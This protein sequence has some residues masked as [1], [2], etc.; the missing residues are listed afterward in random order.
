MS[1]RLCL[2]LWLLMYVHPAHATLPPVRV[3]KA[4]GPTY[5]NTFTALYESLAAG[6]PATAQAQA[7]KVNGDWRLDRPLDI[8]CNGGFDSGFT[9]GTGYTTLGGTL[10]VGSG[11][12]TANRLIVS[13]PGTAPL[14]ALSGSGSVARSLLTYADL[15]G[16]VTPALVDGSAF[17]LPANAAMPAH[18]FEGHL[19]IPEAGQSPV[20]IVHTDDYS[21]A[22]T[23][24]RKVLPAFSFDFVQN[25][26]YLIPATQGLSITGNSYWNYIVG[27]GRVW[28]ETGDQGLSRAS[29]P[30]ALVERNANCTHNGMMT[31]LFDNSSVSK[32]SYE[33][34]QETCKYFKLD[35]AGQLSASY[36]PASVAGAAAIKA[37]HAAE[38]ANRLPT[39]PIAALVDDFP[40]SGVQL[41]NIGKMDQAEHM[42][43]YGLLVNGINY[44]SDCGT[45]YG[46]YPFCD[47]MRLPSYSTAKSAFASMAMMRLG[48]KYGK[49]L[50]Y[51]S[52]IVD[53]IYPPEYQSRPGNWNYQDVTT[54][55]NTLDMAT[56]RF[57]YSEFETDENYYMT[58]FFLAENYDST[59]YY[60]FQFTQYL[61]PGQRWV[62]HSS[63]TFLVTRAMNNFLVYYANDTGKDI[64]NMV[65][66]EVFKPLHLSAG[67]MTTLRT[68]NSS[69]GKP[70]G[71]FGLFWSQDDIA[72]LGLFL[73]NFGG[74]Y[75]DTQILNPEM[76]ADSMQKTS[77][78]G[79]LTSAT[80][81]T[82][83]YNNAFWAAPWGAPYTCTFWTPFMSGYGGISVVM[84][85]NGSTYYEVNDNAETKW[86]YALAESNKLRP[87]CP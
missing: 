31:F 53:F 79:Y 22:S 51:N 56:G 29:F 73:N 2:L 18:V 77:N 85:P 72:K 67:A 35:M 36:T 69:T 57:Y 87:M 33:I 39:R 28:R 14:G 64:F 68:D 81:A 5:H 12:L 78:H 45:R 76:L 24:Q 82:L 43:A 32:V 50:V 84:M 26:S 41:A 21:Y 55:R 74:A 27:P 34:T 10:T 83:Y 20:F 60:A 86:S 9:A 71:G 66:D 7:V 70:F 15:T 11:T 40:G 4:T 46:L 13:T 19:S 47:N 65:R 38:I 23:A 62:Y 80:D 75:D 3:T 52:R 58:N 16:G 44:V 63:D 30:F 8:T 54:F 37:D 42:T 48:Q 59:I 17:A 6:S 25:G 61:P 49:D 1:R